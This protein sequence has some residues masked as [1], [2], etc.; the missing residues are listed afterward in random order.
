MKTQTA[1]GSVGLILC[2]LALATPHNAYAGPANRRASTQSQPSYPINL[3]GFGAP[4][5]AVANSLADL[6]TFATGQINFK[7]IEEMPQL[8]PLFNGTT[9]TGCHSQPATG[10]GGLFINEIRVRNNTDPGPVHIFAVDNMLRNGPQ[11]QGATPIFAGGVTA[12]PL[13]CQ[14]TVPGCQLSACQ[15]EEAMKTTF[16]T[17]LPTCDP[18]SANFTS[19]GDCVAGRAALALFGDGLVEAVPDQTLIQLAQNEPQSIRGT[20]K[21][22]T[23]NFLNTAHVGRFGWKNDHALLRGFAGD[24]YL[25]E[26][27]IT[28]PDNPTDTSSCAIGVT[29]YGI[30]LEDTGIEDTIDPDGRADIDRFSD[31]MRA[32]APPPTIPQNSSALRGKFMF[33]QLGCAGCHAPSLTTAS[34]PASFIPAATG[35]TPMSSTVNHALA[36]QTFHPYGDFLLHDMGALGD[37]ITSGAAGP[38]MMR[39]APLWGLRAKSIFLHDGRALDLPTAISLHDGQGKPASQAFQALSTSQ[40]QDVVNF[41]NTL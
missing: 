9:C 11:S 27:G 3:D 1:L 40:Q 29:Q 23:E 34:N 13:G 30:T 21:M 35:G 38:T 5:P 8:G 4:L 18:T 31:F 16:S 22:V 24:A 32:L 28:N 12:E 26:M 19:G 39:T 33:S 14:I 6:S 20:V 36:Q 41:L 15:Q 37:G 2:A 25:N 7:E 17:E 10:G